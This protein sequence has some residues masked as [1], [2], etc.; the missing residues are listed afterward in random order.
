MRRIYLTDTRVLL[1]DIQFVPLALAVI[2]T[3]CV[4]AAAAITLTCYT[5]LAFIDI[6]QAQ[7]QGFSIQKS[8]NHCVNLIAKRKIC[9]FS[10]FLKSN[11]HVSIPI[12]CYSFWTQARMV[13]F[14]KDLLLGR[15]SDHA[16][17][18]HQLITRKQCIVNTHSVQFSHKTRIV[19]VTKGTEKCTFTFV[20]IPAK[21]MRTATATYIRFLFIE[22]W[23]KNQRCGKNKF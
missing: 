13:L 12:R 1:P 16:C 22:K 6:Q 19:T 15:T 8:Q 10:M 23:K 21:S 11:S 2:S 14:S 17:I 18:A 5:F 3:P 20:A 9:Y 7:N 4:L